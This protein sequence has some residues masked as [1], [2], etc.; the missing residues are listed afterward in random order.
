MSDLRWKVLCWSFKPFSLFPIPYS[1]LPKPS[2]VGP[3]HIETS[4]LSF[5]PHKPQVQ[6]RGFYTAGLIPMND[7]IVNS[8]CVYGSEGGARYQPLSVLKQFYEKHGFAMSPSPVF[9]ANPNS[10]RRLLDVMQRIVSIAEEAPTLLEKLRAVAVCVYYEMGGAHKDL[11]V[12][13]ERHIANLSERLEDRS[14]IIKLSQV[15]TQN[16]GS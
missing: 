4:N 12:A 6:S 14:G 9:L 7:P 3:E 11:S 2:T 10:D 15:R 1:L 13:A 8:F 16:P 5:K